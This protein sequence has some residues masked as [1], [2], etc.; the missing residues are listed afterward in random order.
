[1]KVACQKVQ[2]TAREQRTGVN[3]SSQEK[4]LEEAKLVLGHRKNL[5]GIQ[6]DSMQL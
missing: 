3:L 6:L 5:I 1:M 4:F 2:R